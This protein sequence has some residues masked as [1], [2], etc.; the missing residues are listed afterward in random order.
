M[1]FWTRSSLAKKG[2]GQC[3]SRERRGSIYPIST[4]SGKM[5]DENKTLYKRK[6]M[7]CLERICT[8][9]GNINAAGGGTVQQ[10]IE[11]EK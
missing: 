2:T 10:L 3:N 4:E 5:M 1:G 7:E 11:K 9:V 8:Q 6:G